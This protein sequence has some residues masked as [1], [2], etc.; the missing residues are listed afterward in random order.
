MSP[1]ALRIASPSTIF[2]KPKLPFH[3]SAISANR[4]PFPGFSDY[5]RHEG[6]G[7]RA[8]EAQ[9]PGNCQIHGQLNQT[10]QKFVEAE[11]GRHAVMN[12]KAETGRH[13]GKW[14]ILAIQIQIEDIR[15]VDRHVCGASTLRRDCDFHGSRAELGFACRTEQNDR[16]Q[17]VRPDV[18]GMPPGVVSP[19]AAV[20]E[21]HD[22]RFWTAALWRLARLV[23]AIAHMKPVF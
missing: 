16:K 13:W 5:T 21:T 22:R 10:T 18:T 12:G 23:E 2:P 9:D 15:D 3:A 1:A 14:K 6:T 7:H 20:T 17:H 4:R 8:P 19:T 11:A